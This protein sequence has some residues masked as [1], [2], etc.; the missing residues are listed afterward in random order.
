[1][2]NW[3]FW[4]FAV[5]VPAQAKL[6]QQMCGTD[7]YQGLEAQA[8]H[9]SSL[10]SAALKPTAS[11]ARPAVTDAG[12]VVVMDESEGAVARRNA[13]NLTGRVIRVQPVA[14]AST[15]YRFDSTTDISYETTPAVLGTRPIA[16]DP[17]Y[18]PA[19]ATVQVA[20]SRAALRLRIVSGGGQTTTAGTPLAAPIV[21]ELVDDN[22]LPYPGIPVNALVREGDR[23][24]APSAITDARGRVKFLWTPGIAERR[25][26]LATVEGGPEVWVSVTAK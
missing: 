14:P 25:D 23:L 15:A 26:L 12:N 6:V 22:R 16:A 9:Q 1:M 17:A 13:F 20:G 4:A 24:A 3:V 18:A 2:R 8:I 11:P 21:L 19:L 5:A 10:R 7:G